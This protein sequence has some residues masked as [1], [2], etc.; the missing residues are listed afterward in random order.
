MSRPVPWDALI[1]NVLS[2]W[3]IPGLG[4][5]FAGAR[6][7]GILLMVLIVGLFA[8]G[9]WLS[10]LEAVSK[11]LHP[12]AYYAE[13]GFGGAT[14]PLLYLDPAADKVLYAMDPIRTRQAVP[15]HNDTGTL[16]CSI[17]G[18]LNLLALF[19]LV[20]RYLEPRPTRRREEKEVQEG[21]P[22]S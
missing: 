13:L 15:R 18:L 8:C 20:D 14:V 17:A 12:Y 1:G 5:I 3:L 11:E 19:D 22:A 4:H 10:D 6:R 7:Q 21:A 2:G 16:F 9:L